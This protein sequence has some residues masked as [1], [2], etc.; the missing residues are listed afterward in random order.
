[1]RKISFV[2]FFICL[3]NIFAQETD[4]IKVKTNF[5]SRFMFGNKKVNLFIKVKNITTKEVCVQI[6]QE[7]PFQLQHIKSSLEGRDF[8]DRKRKRF[9]EWNIAVPPKKIET[10]KLTMR[11]IKSSPR[12]RCRTTF[13]YSGRKKTKETSLRIQG[14][15]SG[16]HLSTYDTEDPVEVGQMTTYVISANN[17]ATS[18]A[19][20]T[21][22][23]NDIAEEMI[24]EH[25]EVILS[26]NEKYT[27]NYRYDDQTRKV[28]FD[29]V[30]ILQPGEKITYKITCRAIRSG[31]AKNVVRLR[32]SEFDKEII[33]EEG[34]S[35]YE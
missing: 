24:F 8:V 32:Y 5:S 10:I 18:A 1:M 21:I 30:P 16:Q 27:V 4:P 14:G 2:L 28:C 17:E 15:Y 34:T 11:A 13:F 31:S 23:C 12:V 33:D 25:A 9:I 26:G 29:P 3:A 35:V 19:T 22:V 20:N 6:V 7:I